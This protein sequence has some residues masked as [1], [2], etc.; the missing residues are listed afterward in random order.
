MH[1]AGRRPGRRRAGVRPRSASARRVD[2]GVC[3][4]AVQLSFGG[5]VR[6]QHGGR[7]GQDWDT[8]RDVVAQ[9]C[10]QSVPGDDEAH[11][12]E[13]D[14]SEHSS[15]RAG[16]VVDYPPRPGRLSQ[17]E[18]LTLD[19]GDAV[20]YELDQEVVQIG[21]VAVQDTLGAARFVGDGPG[22]QCTRPVADQHALGRVERARASR[23]VPRS[24]RP[25]PCRTRH[26]AQ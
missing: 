9:P 3:R 25:P 20:Q 13:C 17:D 1:R 2:I 8:G 10:P 19:P 26:A 22:G 14:R 23:R 15:Q 11:D 6:R 21:E 12:H 18:G 4:G 16:E 24:A 7:F 5:E